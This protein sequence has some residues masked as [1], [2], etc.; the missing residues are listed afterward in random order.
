MYGGT[1]SLVFIL[2]FHYIL[3]HISHWRADNPSRPMK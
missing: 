1:Y 2:I 3:H